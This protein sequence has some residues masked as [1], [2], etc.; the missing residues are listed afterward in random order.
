MSDTVLLHVGVVCVN[1]RPALRVCQVGLCGSL[2]VC[3]TAA[4]R[5]AR[6]SSN[7][8]I[9]H[10]LGDAALKLAVAVMS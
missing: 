7:V 8:W 10:K 4:A 1:V 5:R 9:D 6:V 3:E 2:R